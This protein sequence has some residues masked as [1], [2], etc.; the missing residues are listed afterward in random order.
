MLRKFNIF[1]LMVFILS[2]ITYS[3]VGGLDRFGISALMVVNMG[4]LCGKLMT[5][6]RLPN[7]SK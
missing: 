7:C 3:F 1:I 5:M 2:I 4:L 6:M